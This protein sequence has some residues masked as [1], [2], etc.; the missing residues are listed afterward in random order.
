[1]SLDEQII[2]I[3]STIVRRHGL[4][5]VSVALDSALYDDG[6]GLDSMC[7]AE[8]SATLEKRLG[9]DPYTKGELPATVADIVGFYG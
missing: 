7:V 6:V 1:M 4:P 2:D 5:E 9:S 8:L 3:I